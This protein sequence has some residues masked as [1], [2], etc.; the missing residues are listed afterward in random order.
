MIGCLGAALVSGC[1][2][3]PPQTAASAAP[4][5][6]TNGPGAASTNTPV[7]AGPGLTE[8]LQ[9]AAAV[10][11]A[12]FE[13]EGWQSLFDGKT[14]AGWRVTDF[15]SHGPVECRSGL[16]FFDMG[17][18]FTGLNW[19]N[20]CPKINY[21]VALD[22]MRVVGSDFFCGLTVPVN[23]SFCSLIVGGWG[24]SLVGISSLDG[25][26]ASE[27][28]TTKFMNFE[29]DR[30]YRIRMRVCEGRIEVW[31]DKEKL[32]NVV[33]KDRRISLRPGEIELSKPFGLASWQTAAAFREIKIRSVSG[34]DGPPPKFSF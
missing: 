26:D 33:T 27:N 34:P 16:L 19:T 18:P 4:L 13:G 14:L 28:Q 6:T 8:R 17:D 10:P 12:P 22:A 29:K 7:P 3:Q 2:P 23:D 15:V 32:I 1:A 25:M 20:E 24:G 30:W 31:I 5:P 9:K 11:A 21:E